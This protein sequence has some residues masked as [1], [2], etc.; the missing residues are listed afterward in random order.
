[1]AALPREPCSRNALQREEI[2]RGG[3]R[4]HAAGR[5]LASGAPLPTGAE[6]VASR[7][8]PRCKGG[9]G[10]IG[11]GRG[12]WR[13]VAPRADLRSL[14]VEAAGGDGRIR[15]A[16]RPGVT[17]PGPGDGSARTRAAEIL[18]CDSGTARSPIRRRLLGLAVG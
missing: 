18:G 14:G 3:F 9:G 16:R 2:R 4:A 11:V 17:T 15:I 6:E 7:G 12:A 5:D 10:A 1:G 13:R 8:Y